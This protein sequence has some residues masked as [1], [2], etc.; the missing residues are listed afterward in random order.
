MIGG[1]TGVKNLRAKSNTAELSGNFSA[2]S[3]PTHKKI[4][5]QKYPVFV[6]RNLAAPCSQYRRR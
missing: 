6:R 2:A 5:H 4:T 3:L 1:Y